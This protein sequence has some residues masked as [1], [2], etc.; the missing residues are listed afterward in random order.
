MIL[1]GMVVGMAV[2]LCCYTVGIHSRLWGNLPI[3]RMWLMHT[4][5]VFSSVS[6]L[7]IECLS[8]S[9]IRTR[10]RTGCFSIIAVRMFMENV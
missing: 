7:C 3:W 6:P 10:G 1:A 8:D 2:M 4:V 5:M 9:H